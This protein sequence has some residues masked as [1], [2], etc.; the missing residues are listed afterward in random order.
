MLASKALRSA[1]LRLRRA[2]RRLHW[3]AHF[4]AAEHQVEDAPLALGIGEI[5]DERHAWQFWARLRGKLYQD[6]KL[7]LRNPIGPLRLAVQ[8]H[9]PSTSPRS[10]ANVLSVPPG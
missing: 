4:L 9:R 1:S 5:E 2:R 7:V 6:V 8:P 10:I 3:A